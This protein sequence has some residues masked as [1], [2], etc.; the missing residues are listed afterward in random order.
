MTIQAADG[1]TYQVLVAKPYVHNNLNRVSYTVKQQQQLEA[2]DFVRLLM[3]AP[4]DRWCIENP[5][6][7]ISTVIAPPSRSFNH[8][9]SAT[10]K[11]RQPACG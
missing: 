8:G 7:I 5:V 3:A 9:G 4:I 10:A 2:L 1:I 6:S 11:L